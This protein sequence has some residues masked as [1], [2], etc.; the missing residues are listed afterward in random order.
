MRRGDD[1]P[2]DAA[3]SDDA[4]RPGSAGETLLP[5]D[6]FRPDADLG[7]LTV[8]L[9]TQEVTGLP[10]HVP[11]LMVQGLDDDLVT[12]AATDYL[13]ST[14]PAERVTYMKYDGADHRQAVADSFD[15]VLA[16][17]KALF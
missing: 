7:P 11:M 8:Y 1:G 15:D 13:V 9:L 10:V 6:V 17:V 14:L 2:H 4:A 3:L 12:P 5:E 16:F